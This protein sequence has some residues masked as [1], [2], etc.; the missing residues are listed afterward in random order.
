MQH[1]V[2]LNLFKVPETCKS[3]LSILG[4]TG[5]HL[6]FLRIGF[7]NYSLTDQEVLSLF[8]SGDINTLAD[9]A[10]LSEAD[11]KP[12]REYHRCFVSQSL[13]FPYC[14]TLEEIRINRYQPPDPYV[15]GF[16]LRH[17]PRLREFDLADYDLEDYSC[18]IRSLWDISEGFYQSPTSHSSSRD[19]IV[20]SSFTGYFVK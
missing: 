4:K 5:L 1:L 11:A 20:L 13:M 12:K 14:Q 18:G 10:P 7:S 2:S 17:L 6:K 8:F 16:I 19:P 15:V 9:V 3:V